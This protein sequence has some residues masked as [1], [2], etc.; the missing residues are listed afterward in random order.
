MPIEL[1]V[2]ALLCSTL[3]F[4]GINFLKHVYNVNIF[5]DKL[6][7]LFDC[8][9]TQ[10]PAQHPEHFSGI[11]VYKR[12]AYMSVF[13]KDFNNFILDDEMMKEL[14]EGADLYTKKCAEKSREA[15][16]CE[17]AWCDNTNIDKFLWFETDKDN[18]KGTIQCQ[19][20]L[21]TCPMGTYDECIELIQP[22]EECTCKDCN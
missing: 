20:C 2:Y 17:C 4:L 19:E 14:Y 8:Y 16:E 21:A 6:Q 5:Y 7:H 22:L 18:Q 13:E 11:V 9:Y 1:I 15:M 10:Y 12:D 3:V